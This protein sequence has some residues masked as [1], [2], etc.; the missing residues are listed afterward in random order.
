MQLDQPIGRFAGEVLE[1]DPYRL[2]QRRQASVPT[3][4]TDRHELRATS[5]DDPPIRES[6]TRQTP[7]NRPSTRPQA[8]PTGSHSSWCMH[9]C[10]SAGRWCDRC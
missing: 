5:H 9:G 4:H 6:S 2:T 7:M 1:Y 10:R 3:P 8:L